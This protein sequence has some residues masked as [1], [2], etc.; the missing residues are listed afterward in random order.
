VFLTEPASGGSLL[1][2]LVGMLT[3]RKDDGKL[4]PV[5]QLVETH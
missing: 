3:P 5:V 1:V 2:E 4:R